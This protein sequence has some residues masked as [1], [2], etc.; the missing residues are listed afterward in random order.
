MSH[1][2]RVVR[3]PDGFKCIAATPDLPFA[4][5][6]DEARGYYGLQF[7]AEVTHTQQGTPIYPRFVNELRRCGNA[8]KPD[9]HIAD[10]SARVTA[11]A[12][13][14]PVLLGLPAGC[15]KTVG[16]GKRGSI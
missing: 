4:G 2:D 15:R 10:A 7:H 6:A 12:G 11:Q 9:P 5:M 1:G 3:L 8:W 13:H 14:G 16:E